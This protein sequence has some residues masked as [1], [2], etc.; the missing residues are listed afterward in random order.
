FGER[1][2]CLLGERDIVARLGGGEFAVLLCGS[3]HGDVARLCQQILKAVRTPFGVMGH[4]VNA[5]VSIGV[6]HLP[7]H[8]LARIELM[9]KADIALYRAKQEGRNCAKLFS[10]A[11]DEQ[12]RRRND[13]ETELRSALARSELD[14]V[15]QPEMGRDGYGVVGVEA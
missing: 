5:S 8:G 10:E 4:I 7:D 2:A 3:G 11:L 1:V 9:R 14:V 6:V 15:Y 13:I 12:V